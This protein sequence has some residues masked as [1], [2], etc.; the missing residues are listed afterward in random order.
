LAATIVAGMTAV[1]ISETAW[2]HIAAT[3]VYH[4]YRNVYQAFKKMIIDVFEDPY[5]NALSDDIVCYVN[6]TS[7]QLLYHLLTYYA[8]LSPTELRQNYERLKTPYDPNES[9]DN[10]FQQIQDAQAFATAGGQPYG[11]AMIA[12]VAFTLVFNT[13]LFPDAYRS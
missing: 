3:R 8:M 10:L 7:L 6:C 4:T 13:G 12:N 9:I 5:L 2:L 11:D 1:H